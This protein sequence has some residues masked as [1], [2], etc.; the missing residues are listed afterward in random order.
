MR[1]GQQYTICK[2]LSKF[3][4]NLLK[5]VISRTYKLVIGQVMYNWDFSFV[6]GNQVGFLVSNPWH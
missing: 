1:L 4:L 3:Q 5:L 2:F 6:D